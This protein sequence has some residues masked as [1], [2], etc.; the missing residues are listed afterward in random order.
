MSEPIRVLLVDDQ[1]LVN[2]A[3]ASM[4]RPEKDLELKWCGEGVK[5]L[6][7]AREYRPQVILQDL[8]MPDAD[9][10]EIVTAMRADP[11]LKDVPLVV[12]SANDDPA[13][14]AETFA[15][16]A[17]DYLVKLPAAVELVA[18]IR[19]HARGYLALI[20]RNA[21]YS[22]LRA[23]LGEA[24]AY[25]RS[26][27]PPPISEPVLTG[28][29]FNPS[30]SLGGDA[31]AYHRLDDD[32]FALYLLDVCGH[33]VG[34]ALL[35]VSALNT[36]SAQALPGVDFRDPAEVLAALNHAFPMERQNQLYFTIWYGVY[37]LSSHTL[38]Y[39]G[40]GH[41]P[42]VLLAPGKPPE[43]LQGAGLPIGTFEG[44]DYDSF[45]TTV[46]PGSRLYLYSDGV[47]EVE[48][49]DNGG[50]LP[51]DE[52]IDVLTSLKHESCQERVDCIIES[53]RDIQGKEAF[54]DDCSLVEFVFAG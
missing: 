19:H 40:A 29:T 53:I 28:W 21:A 51:F 33:G 2:A 7:A 44:L 6:D 12:L 46:P 17:N 9:G 37:E 1:R 45:S 49:K 27:L 25:V 26:I 5:A 4:L 52:F 18:R 14:K 34:S 16:G 20:E 38:T 22:R 11:E 41:P 36:L 32:H 50:M 47:F 54:D 31:F 15:R 30:S 35:S 10:M 23:E 3:I 42:A 24:A 8:V 39:A 43:L 13:I 48:K